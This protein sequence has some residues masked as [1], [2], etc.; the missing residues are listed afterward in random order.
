MVSDRV[1]DTWAAPSVFFYLWSSSQET[2]CVFSC[3]AVCYEGKHSFF[4]LRRR[5][6]M[7]GKHKFWGA[8]YLDIALILTAG[9]RERGMHAHNWHT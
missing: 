1:R 6:L 4:F 9:A 5:D 3:Q 2:G 8:L 7:Q